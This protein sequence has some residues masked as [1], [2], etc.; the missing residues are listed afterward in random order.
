MVQPNSKRFFFFLQQEENNNNLPNPQ[1][2]QNVPTLCDTINNNTNN[3]KS[4]LTLEMRTTVSKKFTIAAANPLLAEK[5]ASP[6]IQQADQS[7]TPSSSASTY[8]CREPPDLAAL[9]VKIEEGR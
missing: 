6:S 8:S 1:Y 2:D 5:L 9:G 7:M 4:L 3:N